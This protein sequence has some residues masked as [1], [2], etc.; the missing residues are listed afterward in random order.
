[1]VRAAE[2]HGPRDGAGDCALLACERHFPTEDADGQGVEDGW[3]GLVQ[4][5]AHCSHVELRQ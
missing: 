3:V 4:P 5:V 2:I 1:M